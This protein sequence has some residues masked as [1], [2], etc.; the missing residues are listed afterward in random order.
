LKPEPVGNPAPVVPAEEDVPYTPAA[1]DE[2]CFSLFAE[3]RDPAPCPSCGRTGFYGPR[4]GPTG[5]RF[6]ACRFC[7]LHQDVNGPPTRARPSI[8][9]CST[10]P[11]IA[12]APYIWWLAPGR[13]EYHCPFCDQTVQ[14]AATLG[15]VPS[16]EPQHPWWKVPQ[17]RTRFYYARFWENWPF[18]KGRVFL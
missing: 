16:D 11:E 13:E 10:W 1:W 8:H 7:G 9:R 15:T 5:E 18:T 6:R 12:R 4:V 17:N 2:E 14:L 3:G